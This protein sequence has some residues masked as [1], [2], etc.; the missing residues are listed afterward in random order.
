MQSPLAK[1]QDRMEYREEGDQGWRGGLLDVLLWQHLVWPQVMKK[2]Q[3]SGVSNNKSWEQPKLWGRL[4]FISAS[5]GGNHTVAGCIPDDVLAL[6][7]I[8][9]GS[10][11]CGMRPFLLSFKSLIDETTYLF[12]LIP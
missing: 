6:A 9:S 10:R 5:L 12:M 2:T 4:H 7:M 1:S 3:A 11:H 8:R